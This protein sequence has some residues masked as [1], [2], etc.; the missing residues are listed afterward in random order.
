LSTDCRI[1]IVSGRTCTGRSGEANMANSSQGGI[2]KAVAACSLAR[3]KFSAA[4]AGAV[5]LVSVLTGGPPTHAADI[6]GAWA[7]DVGV[8]DKIFR[9][10]GTVLT[11][12]NRSNTLGGGFIIDGDAIRGKNANCRIKAR[13]QA[14]DLVHLVAACA[15]DLMLSN[16]ELTLKIIDDNRVARVFAGMPEM[17]TPYYRCPR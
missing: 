11:L 14:G 2:V 6:N 12:T 4:V 16:Y 8:C 9:K 3:A 1:D 10:K 15:T 17:E 5:I 13:K 7:T